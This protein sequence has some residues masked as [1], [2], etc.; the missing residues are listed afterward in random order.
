MRARDDSS[1]L[2]TLPLACLL[3]LL[4]SYPSSSRFLFLITTLTF[5]LS[6]YRKH[7]TYVAH[8]TLITHT[9]SFSRSAQTNYSHTFSPSFLCPHA[10]AYF[11]YF[12]FELVSFPTAL[13]FSLYLHFCTKHARYYGDNIWHPGKDAMLIVLQLVHAFF[14]I[15]FHQSPSSHGFTLFTF[16]FYFFGLVFL[17][18]CA[19]LFPG[20]D[21]PI[22][23][24]CC[25][26]WTPLLSSIPCCDFC[27]TASS[28]PFSSPPPFF[29]PSP[30]SSPCLF[31]LL[32]TPPLVLAYPHPHQCHIVPCPKKSCHAIS[33]HTS[34]PR[35]HLAHLSFLLLP[36]LPTPTLL[37]TVLPLLT[38]LF[39]VRGSI[40]GVH[41]FLS[42]LLG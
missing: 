5:F 41:D 19:F 3:L 26:L 15:L 16:F 6:F 1:L 22:R 7:Y 4:P 24:F 31:S 12:P 25:F 39:F 40:G 9:R 10:S 35:H 34:Q 14:L 13:T 32:S 30:P 37:F 36:F 42:W 2:L 17:I 28:L 27:P 38:N 33:Y 29:I 23:V 11:L 8:L 20:G 18:A 21:H